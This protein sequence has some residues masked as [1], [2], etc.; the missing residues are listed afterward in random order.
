MLLIKLRVSGVRRWIELLGGRRRVL[1]RDET[2]LST[3]NNEIQPASERGSG[4]DRIPEVP[5]GWDVH[6]RPE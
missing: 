3:D 5:K 6:R 1:Q 4:P 2:D